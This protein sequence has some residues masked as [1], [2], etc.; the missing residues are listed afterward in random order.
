MPPPSFCQ[1]TGLQSRLVSAG[2]KRKRPSAAF[3]GGGDDDR[4]GGDDDLGDGDD[5]LGNGD[6]AGASAAADAVPEAVLD[7]AASTADAELNCS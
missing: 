3:G 1:A 2:R 4:G 5:D 6:L 7:E